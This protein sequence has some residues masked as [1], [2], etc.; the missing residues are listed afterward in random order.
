M[1]P[2]KRHRNLLIGF[3]S[4]PC[5][6]SAGQITLHNGDVIKGELTA[7]QAKVV[8]WKSQSFGPQRI[9]KSKIASIR[10]S[11][12][13]KVPGHDLPCK[14]I[15]MKSGH[16]RYYCEDSGETS[17]SLFMLE[18]VQPYKD[19]ESGAYTYSGR[20]SVSGT[21]NRGNINQDDIDVFANISFQRGEYR[22]VIETSYESLKIDDNTPQ[23][24]IELRYRLDWFLAEQW[25]WYNEVEL[26]RDD[27]RNVNQYLLLSSGV[28]YEIWND[29]EG[30]LDVEIGAEYSMDNFHVTDT[31]LT[32]PKFESDKNQVRLRLG[33]N[34]EHKLYGENSVF[35][36]NKLTLLASDWEFSMDLGLNVPLGAG[37]FSELVAEYDYLSEPAGENENADTKITLGIGYQW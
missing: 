18:N 25:F 22:H 10:S 26:G 28:G 2:K 8:L 33:S 1:H 9:D 24:K 31:D 36:R 35:N 29:A 32:D 14:I 17:L 4:L 23:E 21:V 37:L 20:A 15:G 16:L 30:K 12:L 27:F 11:R 7:I 19:F 13:L 34:L 3:L 6:A 5:L